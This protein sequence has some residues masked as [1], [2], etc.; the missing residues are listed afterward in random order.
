MKKRPSTQ[1]LGIAK[2]LVINV[3][4]VACGARPSSSTTP[5]A[6]STP[7]STPTATVSIPTKTSTVVQSSPFSQYIEFFEDGAVPAVDLKPSD[8][9][10]DSN[11]I[12][13]EVLRTEYIN[14]QNY[15]PSSLGN[16]LFYHENGV[17]AW[18]TCH[19]RF[20]ISYLTPL[21]HPAI[22]CPLQL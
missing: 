10:T 6:T 9:T 15:F 16:K 7:S 14:L 12:T 21:H 22:I 11:S 8:F 17:V 1:V 5:T 3:L 19:S 18:L 13:N 4:L 2:L 20:P